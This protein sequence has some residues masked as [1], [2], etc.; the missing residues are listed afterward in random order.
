M[1]NRID[2]L[3]EQIHHE[4]RELARLYHELILPREAIIA[5]LKGQV[6]L[7]RLRQ[8]RDGVGGKT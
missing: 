1:T 3:R 6:A 7:E 4:R 2:D 8:L 5:N